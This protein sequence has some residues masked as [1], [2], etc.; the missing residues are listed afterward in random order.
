MHPERNDMN[1]RNIDQP[2]VVINPLFARV[3]GM[4]ETMVVAFPFR[5][6]MRP[7]KDPR[8]TPAARPLPFDARRN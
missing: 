5:A 1:N 8:E 7:A 6:G 4:S 3:L 2:S